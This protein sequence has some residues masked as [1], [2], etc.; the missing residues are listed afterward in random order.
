MPSQPPPGSFRD[1]QFYRVLPYN[2]A[3][4]AMKGDSA[5]RSG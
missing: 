4:S 5:A 2:N 1:G 3:D